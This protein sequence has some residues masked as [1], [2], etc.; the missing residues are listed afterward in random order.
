M[1]DVKLNKR[2]FV[3]IRGVCIP[4]KYIRCIFHWLISVD[5]TTFL[6]IL[7]RIALLILPTLDLD[8]F[9]KRHG[10]LFGNSSLGSLKVRYASISCFTLAQS[11]ID[12]FS[13]IF[14]AA[15]LK[16]LNFFVLSIYIAFISTY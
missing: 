11:A 15:R 6:L 4:V 10:I 7:S 5:L 12:N 2:C 8:G 9:I 14:L 3:F 16:S 13:A 1:F